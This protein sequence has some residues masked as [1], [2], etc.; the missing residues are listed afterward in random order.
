MAACEVFVI[1]V[2]I[3]NGYEYVDLGLP[4]GLKWATMNVGASKP[5][6]CGD[7]YA[8][9]ETEPKSDY[10]WATY[11]FRISGDGSWDGHKSNITFSKYCNQ[12]SNWESSEP[13]DNKTV[14]DLEDDAAHV[15][16]GGSW[17]MPTYE[18]YVELLANC[19]WTRSTQNG[20]NG[21]LVSGPN[22]NSIFF[23]AAGSIDDSELHGVGSWCYFWSSSLYTER[24]S[25]AWYVDFTSDSGRGPIGRNRGYS[26]RPVIE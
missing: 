15:N 16:W 18:E 6:E 13:M 8:W 20:V 21:L 1:A 2:T 14:L 17:R 11:K 25:C 9:G 3:P 7:Y 12:S 4:S 10:S 24:P 5:E 26:V 22:G 23:P 19:T